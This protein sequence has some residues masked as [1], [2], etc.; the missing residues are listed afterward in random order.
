MSALDGLLTSEGARIVLDT[1]A[2]WGLRR[3]AHLADR[4]ARLNEVLHAP[5]GLVVPAPAHMEMLF[6]LRQRYGPQ[7]D[8]AAVAQG[9]MDKG[10]HVEPF[11]VEDADR[12]AARLAEKF[13][14]AGDWHRAKRKRCLHCLGVPATASRATGKGCGATLDWL[15]AVHGTREG[16]ILVT[17]DSDPEF[18]GVPRKATLVELEASLDRLIAAR[19]GPAP[20][21]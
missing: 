12:A 4:V 17:D 1:N 8:A 6:D 19:C 16:W 18:E 2:A 11:G 7:Y 3:L 5:L 20:S 21:R 15:I 13:P 10:I 9:L 14:A